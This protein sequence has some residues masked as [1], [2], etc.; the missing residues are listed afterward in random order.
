[1]EYVPLAKVKKLLETEEKNRELTNEQ[2]LALAHAQNFSHLS[3]AKNDKLLKELEKLDFIS[4]LNAIKIA[5][6]LPSHPD[7]SNAIFAKERFTLEKPQVTSILE[8]VE[9]YL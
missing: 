4:E 5:D 6:M 8:I 7:D 1:M 9:K 2:K 3:S